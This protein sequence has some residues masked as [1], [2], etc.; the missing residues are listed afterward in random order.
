MNWKQRIVEESRGKLS[1][2]DLIWQPDARIELDVQA[3]ASSISDIGK[4]GD[5]TYVPFKD[6]VG[7]SGLLRD[8]EL[9]PLWAALSGH[10]FNASSNDRRSLED[11]FVVDLLPAATLGLGPVNQ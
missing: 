6:A 10:D 4:G 5:W 2:E 3:F 7:D 9:A 8:A 11:P 1:L